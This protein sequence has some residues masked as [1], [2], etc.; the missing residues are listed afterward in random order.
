MS[1]AA[2]LELIA[3]SANRDLDA[4]YDFFEHSKVVWQSFGV[5]VSGGHTVS[6]TT[7]GTGT[8]TDQA[9]LRALGPTYA[10]E[11]LAMLTFRQF[12]STFES[13]FFDFLHRVL[14]HNP[15]QFARSQFDLETV[16]RSR[17]CEEVIGLVL[18]KQMNELRY[19]KPADWFE[20]LNRAV[21]LGCPTTDEVDAIAEMKATR[22]ILE[23]NAGVVNE[24]YVRKAGK[25]AR[26]AVGELVEVD[27]NYHLASWRLIRKV[28]ADLTTAATA[29]LA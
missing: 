17:D 5:F 12:I 10:R 11:F 23:H 27:D 7:K 3:S 22:D 13:F 19:G 24:V 2:D 29:K 16:L 8:T 25:S 26:F 14:R 9:G 21:N 6:I 18:L 15:W 4:V 1:V 28:I 20:A